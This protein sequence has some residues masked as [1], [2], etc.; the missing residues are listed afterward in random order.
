MKF[1]AL[2]IDSPCLQVDRP[3]ACECSAASRHRAHGAS[4]R[5]VRRSSRHEE[6]HA[7]V[8][9]T[10]PQAEESQRQQDEVLN[11]KQRR[12]IGARVV[13]AIENAPRLARSALF[14]PSRT[15]V[16]AICGVTALPPGQGTG[17]SPCGCPRQMPQLL[18]LATLQCHCIHAAPSSRPS[19]RTQR[20]D[21]AR[22][23][24][25]EITSLASPS[26]LN[27]SFRACKG[28]APAAD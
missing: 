11:A 25:E 13:D 28:L 7:N 24:L 5:Q 9:D 14:N 16:E 12:R 20:V 4:R 6:H 8:A 2:P 19:A 27:G 1:Q 26:S 18:L 17:R 15:R 22:S 23:T 21:D 3:V 10:H